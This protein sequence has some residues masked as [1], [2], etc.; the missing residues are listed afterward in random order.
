M[1]T[2]DFID[3]VARRWQ[4]TAQNVRRE[5]CQ[6]LFLAYF[7]ERGG[8]DKICFKGGTALRLVFGSPRF[9]E[10][11]DFSIEQKMVRNLKDLLVETLAEVDREGMRGQIVE[12][13]ATSGGYLA[14]IEFVWSGEA[15]PVELNFSARRRF[16]GE[17]VMV[18]SDLVLGYLVRALETGE[19]VAEKIEALLARQKPRDF[20]DLYFLLRRGLIAVGQRVILK[21]V[22]LIL[23]KSRLDFEGELK[24]FLPRSHWAVIR[25]FKVTL[26]REMERY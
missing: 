13:K 20:Y 22:K 2:V 4:T 5:Y 26:E 12:A 1:P 7:Y 6:H 19:L 24:R 16:T 10:D 18:T 9:S 23:D 14:N 25:N 17:T 15:V 3:D 21:K 11:L 8:T